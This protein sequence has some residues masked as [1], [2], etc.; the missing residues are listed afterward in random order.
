VC[1]CGFCAPPAFFLI[2]LPWVAGAG[3]PLGD[4]SA[5]S[6][7]AGRADIVFCEPWESPHWWQNGYVNHPRLENPVPATEEDIA[8][9]SIESEGCVTGRCLRVRMKQFE[10]GSLS[11]QYPSA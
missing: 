3:S 2:A 9:T 11:L 7:L 4:C 8:L 6:G 5:E 10:P 1:K